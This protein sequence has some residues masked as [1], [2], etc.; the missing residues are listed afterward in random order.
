MNDIQ[1]IAPIIEKISEGLENL[2]SRT[3]FESLRHKDRVWEIETAINLYKKTNNP[4][5]LDHMVSIFKKTGAVMMEGEDSF[6]STI[7]NA[8]VQVQGEMEQLENLFWELRDN[9]EEN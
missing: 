2:K 9:I 3:N 4:D 6:D 5:A 1:K 8:N 7:W